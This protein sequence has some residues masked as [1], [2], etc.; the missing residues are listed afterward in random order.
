MENVGI[1]YA[2][3]VNFMAIGNILWPF[4]IFCDHLV[5]F[6]PVLVCCTKKNLA[7]PIAQLLLFLFFIAFSIGIKNAD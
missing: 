6:S 7:T 3:W 2:H 4:C 5:Y 1:C